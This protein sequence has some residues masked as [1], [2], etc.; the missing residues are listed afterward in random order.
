MRAGRQVTLLFLA[1]PLLTAGCSGEAEQQPEEA[2]QTPVRKQL[3]GTITDA[4]GIEF[5]LIH[6][7]TFTMGRDEGAGDQRPAHKV[8]ITR[9]FYMSVKEIT[10]AQYELV[11]DDNPSEIENLAAP[12]TNITWNDA[13]EFCERLSRRENVIYRLPT[14]AEWEYAYRAGTVTRYYWGDTFDEQARKHPNPWGLMNLAGGVREWCLDWYAPY[15]A[16]EIDD[17]YLD[18]RSQKLKVVRGG[19][20]GQGAVAPFF[21]HFFRGYADPDTS[22]EPNIGFRVVRVE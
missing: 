1:L 6:P 14:E 4:V 21:T 19:C 10:Q 16:E 11:M 13:V 18:T 3:P 20:E 8:T 15:A 12:V 5:V 22:F 7:G 9:P 2:A 17:P